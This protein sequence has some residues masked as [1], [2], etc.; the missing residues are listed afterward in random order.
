MV[1]SPVKTYIVP[2]APAV[3]LEA[4]GQH[5][6][7]QA[8]RGG[9]VSMNENGQ[10]VV[11][12]KAIADEDLTFWL[13]TADSEKTVPSFLI[14][15]GG[16]FLYNAADSATNL[17]NG[18]DYVINDAAD[19]Y[20]MIFKAGSLNE[21][22]LLVTTINGKEA[23]LAEKADAL[24]KYT[25]GLN[26]FKYRIVKTEDEGYYFI[27]PVGKGGYVQNLNGE[28]TTTTD[29]KEA[30]RVL[31]EAME[32]PTSNESVSTSEVKVVAQ[33]GAVVVKNA[34]G[35]NVVVST[36]VGQVVVN[37][38]LTSDNAT[39]NVPAGIVVVAVEGERFKVNV[40]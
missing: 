13:D 12:V 17:V 33:D 9:Y 21:D 4:K 24:K 31:V 37:E 38:V 5:V 7:F 22:G 28:L 25:K 15:K 20:K 39:I 2:E 19:K 14:S 30:L 18:A 1:K 32:A 16:K 34:A 6:A 23:T 29:K 35:K 3:S 11:A 26:D 36:I 8:E 40:K 27:C 10:A